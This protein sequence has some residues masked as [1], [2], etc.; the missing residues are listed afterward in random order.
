[1]L[2]SVVERTREIGIRKALGAT[3]SQILLQFFIEALVLATIGS[4]IGLAI[5]LTVAWLVNALLIVRISGIVAPI[6]W[7]QSALIAIV[8]TS[9]VALAFGTYPAYRAA[10]M[11]PIEA[12]R[13]E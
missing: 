11:D 2:V 5:G 4:A 1:M 7:A 8:F 12:L 10:R 9:V 13:Y 6:P 3:R